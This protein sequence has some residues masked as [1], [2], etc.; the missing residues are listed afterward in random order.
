MDKSTR[1]KLS[2]A[3]NPKSGRFEEERAKL[4]LEPSI[5]RGK[6]DLQEAALIVLIVRPELA[7]TGNCCPELL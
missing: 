1:R 4:D 5:M 2:I 3:A 6:S 7:I